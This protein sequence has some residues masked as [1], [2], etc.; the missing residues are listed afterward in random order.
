MVIS[1]SGSTTQPGW[2]R[3][4]FAAMASRSGFA[5]NV[6]AYWLWSAATASATAAFSSGG[7]GECGNPWARLTAPAATARRFISPITGPGQDSA[8][9]V[10]PGTGGRGGGTAGELGVRFLV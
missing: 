7:A 5:P 8:F 3:A 2:K 6:I 1:R 4:V 9:R 10:V